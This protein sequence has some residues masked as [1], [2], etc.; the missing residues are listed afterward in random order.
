LAIPRAEECEQAL[1]TL[2]EIAFFL[3]SGEQSPFS[4][5]AE[6]LALDNKTRNLWVKKLS[7]LYEQQ[8]AAMEKANKGSKR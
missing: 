2:E 6:V 1:E 8:R 3:C 4:S 5:R 7:D